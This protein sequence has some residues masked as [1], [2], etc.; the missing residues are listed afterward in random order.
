MFWH[1]FCN[2]LFESLHS[3][4]DTGELS[5]LGGHEVIE[6]LDQSLVQSVDQN[7]GRSASEV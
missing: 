3:L 1:Q 7:S 5:A 6:P 2:L 4:V